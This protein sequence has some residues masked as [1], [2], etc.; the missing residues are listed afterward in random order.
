VEPRDD[1]RQPEGDDD[2]H[3]YDPQGVDR[4]IQ[5]LHEC[6]ECKGEETEAGDESGDD[7]ERLAF[8]ADASGQDYGKDRKNTRREDCDDSG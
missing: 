8:P 6:R 5:C 4:Y 3:G 2:D 1:H 7:T